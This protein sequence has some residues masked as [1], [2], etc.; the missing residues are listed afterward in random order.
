[1]NIPMML[2]PLLVEVA[3]TLALLLWSGWERVVAARR[4]DVKLRE[5]A[6]REAGWPERATQVSNAYENQLE[7]PVL[8]YVLT[9]LTLITS[10]Q[11]LLFVVLAWAF[12]I[13]RLGHATIHVTTN[14]V[15]R[16]FFWFLG[17]AVIL[18]VMWL[19]FAA[20]ILFGF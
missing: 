16:R 3:L 5:V 20:E 14:N 19:I 10:R 6:L 8:F 15:P 9:I 4:G 11:T 18:F 1:M 12:V 17:G 13:A 7:L 2:A